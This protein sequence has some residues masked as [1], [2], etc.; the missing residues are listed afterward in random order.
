MDKSSYHEKAVLELVET[1]GRTVYI[2][3]F[4]DKCIQGTYA[5]ECRLMFLTWLVHL[6]LNSCNYIEHPIQR[7]LSQVVNFYF[8]NFSDTL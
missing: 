8:G 5:S 6:F 2:V 7:N 3:I 1:L 4:P